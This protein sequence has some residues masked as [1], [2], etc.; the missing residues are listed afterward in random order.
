[1]GIE[2]IWYNDEG[3]KIDNELVDLDNQEEQDIIDAVNHCNDDANQLAEH[4]LEKLSDKQL[5]Q[6]LSC[7]FLEW[8]AKGGVMRYSECIKDGNIKF[9]EF[10][11]RAALQLI[12]KQTQNNKKYTAQWAEAL[13]NDSN[14]RTIDERLMWENKDQWIKA[15]WHIDETIVRVLQKV[16]WARVDWKPWPQT[17][18]KTVL[19]LGGN[20][21][22]YYEQV[23]T[24]YK[25]NKELEIHDVGTFNSSLLDWPYCYD[26]LKISLYENFM[27]KRSGR[28]CSLPGRCL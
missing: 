1:M 27:K 2:W 17:I 9:L 22:K 4:A 5:A 10:W 3:N 19:K 24:I 25:W 15:D 23:N 11:L 14:A 16:V 12:Q 21:W 13:E 28:G 6:F 8:G 26:K 7:T 18:V 20:V